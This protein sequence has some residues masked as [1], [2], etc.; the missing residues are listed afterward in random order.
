MHESDSGVDELGESG[1]RLGNSAGKLWQEC[2]ATES[3]GD[4]GGGL[5]GKEQRKV[6]V[7][8]SMCEWGDDRWGTRSGV[9]QWK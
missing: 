7:W 6:A 4:R 8:D 2:T 1:G 3:A 5:E 9:A